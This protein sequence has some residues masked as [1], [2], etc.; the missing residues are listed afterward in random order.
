MARKNGHT[1]LT[2]GFKPWKSKL[3]NPP[4]WRK[5]FPFPL[6]LSFCLRLSRAPALPSWNFPFTS[7]EGCAQNA[8]ASNAALGGSGRRLIETRFL[9]LHTAPCVSLVVKKKKKRKKNLPSIFIISLVLVPILPPLF[10]RLLCTKQ[11]SLSLFFFLSPSPSLC[12]SVCCL[13]LLTIRVFAENRT[14]VP[15][16]TVYVSIKRDGDVS[17]P[18][19]H[20]DSAVNLPLRGSLPPFCQLDNPDSQGL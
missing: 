2:R 15:R 12:L 14:G 19:N 10:Q 17:S 4:R 11:F 20:H 7:G 16:S 13:P 18:R 1:Q 6:P 9:K 3:K 8:A 5:F